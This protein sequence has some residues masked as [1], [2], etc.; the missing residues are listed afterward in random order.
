[1]WV[2]SQNKERLIKVKDFTV[3]G[4]SITTQIND[5]YID[6]ITLGVY[7]TKEKALKVMDMIQRTIIQ[8]EIVYAHE[9]SGSG[10]R[11]YDIFRMP[12]DSEVE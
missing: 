2:R 11:D 1:M 10:V 3:D 5:N 8:N 6:Y 4:N 12:Q 9:F 7:S